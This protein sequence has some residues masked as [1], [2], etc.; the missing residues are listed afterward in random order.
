MYRLAGPRS[1]GYK[2]NSTVQVEE[3]AIWFLERI[4]IHSGNYDMPKCLLGILKE[5]FIAL[6]VS[7]EFRLRIGF[8]LGL[9][10][11]RVRVWH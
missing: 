4:Q 1:K 6:E 8:K 5:A 3:F 2:N 7:K 11:V 9:A 10:R